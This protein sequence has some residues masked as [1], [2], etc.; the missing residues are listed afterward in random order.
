LIGDCRSDPRFCLY[1]YRC[2]K[3]EE[4]ARTETRAAVRTRLSPFR[5]AAV[6]LPEI[7]LM[8]RC[9]LARFFAAVPNKERAAED[10]AKFFKFLTERL[11]VEFGHSVGL[12]FRSAAQRALNAAL[13]DITASATR[14]ADYERLVI[15]HVV[16]KVSA[17]DAEEKPVDDARPVSMQQELVVLFGLAEFYLWERLLHAFATVD[18]NATPVDVFFPGQPVPGDD[19]DYSECLKPLLEGCPAAIGWV[20]THALSI[21]KLNRKPTVAE[22]V[23]YLVVLYQLVRPIEEVYQEC[24]RDAVRDAVLVFDVAYLISKILPQQVAQTIGGILT[25]VVR[26][27]GKESPALWSREVRRII[28]TMHSQWFW[29]K[30]PAQPV[31]P[32]TDE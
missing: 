5:I 29:W 13:D 6:E 23:R 12:V 3:R 7:E 4:A 9:G 32:T 18:L 28:E 19:T 11:C 27:M 16:P 26:V 17:K 31:E 8:L 25:A 21:T 10:F 1:C 24:A 30:P 14:A 2:L 15:E 20:A 22:A